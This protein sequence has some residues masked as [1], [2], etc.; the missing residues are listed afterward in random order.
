MKPAKSAGDVMVTRMVTIPADMILA[1]AARRPAK[2][3]VG[4]APV[5]LPGEHKDRKSVARG[6]SVDLGGRRII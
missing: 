5:V 2:H 6:K 3:P 1:D 4:S